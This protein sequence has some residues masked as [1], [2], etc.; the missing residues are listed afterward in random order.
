MEEGPEE[1]EEEEEASSVIEAGCWP[2]HQLKT[3]KPEEVLQDRETGRGGGW[4]GG[5]DEEARVAL[6]TQLS[7]WGG[8]PVSQR[9]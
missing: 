8:G 9:A 1:E 3:I 5:Q 4:P 7:L 2:N 6:G